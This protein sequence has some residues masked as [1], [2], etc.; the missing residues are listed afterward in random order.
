MEKIEIPQ[1]FKKL[2]EIIFYLPCKRLDGATRVAPRHTGLPVQVVKKALL[3][4]KRA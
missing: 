4:T 3:K 2:A 1:K